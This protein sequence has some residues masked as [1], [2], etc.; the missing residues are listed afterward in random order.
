[1][2]LETSMP[3]LHL[4]NEKAKGKSKDMEQKKQ[5]EVPGFPSE[6]EMY[7]LCVS[8]KN[9]MSSKGKEKAWTFTIQKESYTK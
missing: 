3:F 6:L 7:S 1:M 2:L 4:E 8:D 9:W 5:Q